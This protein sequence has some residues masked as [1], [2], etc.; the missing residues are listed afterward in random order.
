MRITFRCEVCDPR[1]PCEYIDYEPDEFQ[2][3]EPI[4]PRDCPH[5]SGNKAKFIFNLGETNLVYD[6]FTDRWKSRSEQ[7]TKLPSHDTFT[8][9]K[10]SVVE[11]GSASK[12]GKLTIPVDFDDMTLTKLRIDNALDSLEYTIAGMETLKS[13]HNIK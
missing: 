8:I 5:H 6:E 11:I 2:D 9:S 13:K 3:Q 7:T 4:P 12:E 10:N 1:Y